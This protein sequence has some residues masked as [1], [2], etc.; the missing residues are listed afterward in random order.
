MRKV[1]FYRYSYESAKR[2]GNINDW[3]ES[4]QANINCKRYIDGDKTGLSSTA[5]DG[6]HVD[7]NYAKKVVEEFGYERTMYVLANTVR[8]L[9]EDG[10]WS[11]K[12]RDWAKDIYDGTIHDKHAWSYVLNT[13]TG[14]IDILAKN[15]RKLYDDLDLFSFTHCKEG[16]LDYEDQV[17][18]ISPKALKEEY[19]KPEYQLW[20]AT[21][22]FGC[23][24]TAVGRA[25]YATCL[26]DDDQNRWD[27]SN[28]IGVIKEEFLPDWAKQKL[29]EMAHS[30]AENDMKM[31]M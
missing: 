7:E 21:N 9:R 18:V 20:K 5:Y 25:V 12:V 27:R 30:Q 1:P 29:E 4:L 14:L 22:G 24:S 19:W 13:H 26:F 2:D 23:S 8:H 6:F 3:N 17:V 15:V 28:V 16:N 10:R 31:N 11:Q